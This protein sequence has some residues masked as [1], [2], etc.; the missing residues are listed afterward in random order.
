MS[1]LITTYLTIAAMLT[2]TTF[3][4]LVPTVITAGHAIRRRISARARAAYL[5][6][7]SRRLA[8]A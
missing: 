6:A 1:S 7:V 4:V 8:A 3:P 5:P 2:L